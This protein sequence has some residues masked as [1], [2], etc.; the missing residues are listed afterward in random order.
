MEKE[1]RKERKREGMREGKK[2]GGRREEK[3]LTELRLKAIC[4]FLDQNCFSLNYQDFPVT[5]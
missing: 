1:G 3:E 5:F 2:E 4:K